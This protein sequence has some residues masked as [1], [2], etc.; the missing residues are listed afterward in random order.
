MKI[1]FGLLHRRAEKGKLHA[2]RSRGVLGL[3]SEV[4]QFETL[5]PLIIYGTAVLAVVAVMLVGSYLLGQRGRDVGQPFESGIVPVGT[6]QIHYAVPFYL[7]AIFFVIFDLEAIFLFAWAVAF[8]E[9]GWAGY[10]EIIIFI[11][12][13]VAALIYLWRIGALDWRTA[14]QKRQESIPR[15][16]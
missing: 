12:I 11:G 14:R 6:S 4:T 10:I 8:R 2:R 15:R 5:W 1:L 9:S 7:V 16:T 3:D 13:L